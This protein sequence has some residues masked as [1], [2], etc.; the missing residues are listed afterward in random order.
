MKPVKCENVSISKSFKKYLICQQQIKYKRPTS[1][2][3]KFNFLTYLS[4]YIR[5]WV[6]AWQSF[7]ESVL[8]WFDVF[9][10]SL[11][12]CWKMLGPFATASS[13]TPPVLHCHSPGVATVA[14]TTITRD[15]G[16][17]YGPMEGQTMWRLW[18]AC[19]Y[20][21]LAES[22]VF[23][24]ETVTWLIG[25]SSGSS[26][27]RVQVLNNWPSCWPAGGEACHNMVVRAWE[28]GSH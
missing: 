26:S 27:C 7:S 15:R 11:L 20:C 14:T 1:R 9:V 10:G 5:Q 16:D 19:F 4:I 22:I 12:M 21:N 6:K 2:D 23:C 25:T 24:V 3:S 8:H 17:R 13:R 18:M 28:V